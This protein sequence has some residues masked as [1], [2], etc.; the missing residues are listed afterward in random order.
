MQVMRMSTKITVHSKLCGFKTVVTVASD[1]QSTKVNL[2]SDCPK[3]KNYGGSLSV[4]RKEDLYRAET[5][6]IF[7][8]AREARLTPTCVVP[9]AVMNACWIEN[10]LISKNLALSSKEIKI[11]FE[12]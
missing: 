4:V 11:I 12:E 6:Q 7:L 9:V 1:G 3:I 10:Q 5:S 2:N 8:R